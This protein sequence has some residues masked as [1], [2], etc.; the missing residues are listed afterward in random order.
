M[1]KTTWMF[2]SITAALLVASFLIAGKPQP[3]VPEPLNN[4]ACTKIKVEDCLKKQK[5]NAPGEIMMESLSRQLL[6]S[7][8]FPR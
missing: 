6:S 3:T 2:F 1:K 4:T 7:I 5:S 8:A